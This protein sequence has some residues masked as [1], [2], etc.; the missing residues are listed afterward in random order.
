MTIAP[1]TIAQMAASSRLETTRDAIVATFKDL[2][3]GVTVVG[4]PGKLDINDVLAKAIVGTPGIALGWSR[5]RGVRDPG[6]S[7]GIPVDWVAYIVTE[8]YADRSQSPPRRIARDVIAYGV[9]GHLLRIL[10]DADAPFWGLT[11]ISEP[12]TDP[13]PEMRP[14]VTMKTAEAGTAVYAV[15]WSQIL[16]FEG[17][18]LFGGPKPAVRGLPDGFEFDIADGDVP[19]E[20][21]A[22]LGREEAE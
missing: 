9:G 14:V 4:H 21:L 17:A 12:L 1:L 13:A 7:Q 10:Q 16:L 18:S 3:R 15:T 19:T 8:D 5:L 6:G 11:G 22:L 2:C 20:I